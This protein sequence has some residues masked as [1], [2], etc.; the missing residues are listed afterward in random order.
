MFLHFVA[1]SLPIGPQAESESMNRMVFRMWH[2]AGLALLAAALCVGVGSPTAEAEDKGRNATYAEQGWSKAE[3][4][5]WQ[6]KPAG[7]IL[8]P[9]AWL[10]SIE[11]ADSADML[12][13][14]AQILRY[15]LLTSPRGPDNPEGL[16]VGFAVNPPGSAAAGQV[17]LTCAACHTG[18]ITYRGKALR[19]DGGGT[20][21]DIPGFVG[22]YYAALQAT[23][24]DPTKWSRFA[25]RVA[26]RAG[27]DNEALRGQVGQVLKA[28]A[29]GVAAAEPYAAL[30]VVSGPGRMDPLNRIGNYLLGQR[31][32]VPENVYASN[33]PANSP[34]LWDVWKFDWVHYNA[35][36]S[37]PMSRNILQVLGNGGTTNFVDETGEPV[38]GPARWDTSI[39]F[40]ALQDLENGYRKLSAPA[41]P[42][43]LFGPYDKALAVRGKRLFAQLCASCHAPR[44]YAGRAA[45][46]AELAVTLVP[47]DA[48]G[49]DPA[50]A[51]TYVERRYDAAKL[52]G[53]SDRISGSEGL[54]LL[55]EKIK[56]LGYDKLGYNKAQRAA[57]DGFGRPNQ[58]RGVLA[59]KARTLDGVWSTGP[60]LH[61]GSVPNIYELLSPVSERSKVFWVGNYEYD[62]VKL[63]HVSRAFAGGFRFDTAMPGNSNK[64][65]EF[66]NGPKGDGV[67]GRLLTHKERMALIEYLKALKDMPPA[68]LPPVQPRS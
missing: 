32:L 48:I 63:G 16:P 35:S 12:L 25:A 44:P 43:E 14:E 62:P 64:G 18:Q 66:R 17:G 23:Y 6:H 20:L 39:D 58:V 51:T 22:S 26:S 13:D 36:F 57:A 9:L 41:W 24:D 61:N 65:H 11:Q 38:R 21:S 34:F 42:R 68:A 46:Q 49:T 7:Q 10:Q 50:H 19:F 47:L 37:Q 53:S 59:Y 27:T 1:N 30:E 60:F 33:A 55:I 31:L 54:L 5:Y 40:E 28:L 56:D 2:V 15:N 52:T 8:A 29:W 67:I 45:R 3:R 4:A